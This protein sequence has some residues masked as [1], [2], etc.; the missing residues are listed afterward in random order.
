MSKRSNPGEVS[1]RAHKRRATA[2]QNE[3]SLLPFS[4]LPRSI[5]NIAL[6]LLTL[7]RR[8]LLPKP[9]SPSIPKIP[10]HLIA[11]LILPFVADRTTWDS[12]YCASKE[13]YLAGKKMTPPWP[14]NSFN[15]N[16]DPGHQVTY[17]TFSPSGSQ[18]A[19]VINGDQ[20]TAGHQYVGRVW[21]RW[22]KETLLAGHTRFIHCLEYS[23]DGEYLASGSQDGSIR[24]RH[25]D[26][27]QTMTSRERPTSTPEQADTILLGGSYGGF[28]TLSFS[29]TDSNLLVSGG[30]DNR[31]KIWN[32]RERICIQSFSPRRSA[33]VRSLILS[34]GADGVCIAAAAHGSKIR[35]WRAE[36]Y[37]RFTR[38]TISAAQEGQGRFVPRAVFSPS[39]SF[40]ATNMHSDHERTSTL[41][42]YD[43]GTMTKT[44]SVVMPGPMVTRFVISPDS[45]QLALCDRIGGIRL[46]QTD[47]FNIQ[48]DLVPRAGGSTPTGYALAFDPTSQILAF[49]CRR[50]RLE[51]RTL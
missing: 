18:V 24:V 33:S 9:P 39:G 36:G 26:S 41:S 29:R 15:L 35:L 5:W 3:E 42:L 38:R 47:D 46:V 40:L 25:T 6:G 23:S 21:D 14:D 7:P 45:K 51:L 27:F 4:S 34:G 1:S 43:L 48:R 28:R 13:L 44:Q 2:P 11:D 22:G 20:R 16:L 32:V 37:S 10:L 8:F 12:V 30:S 49:A 31:V 19:F 17:V 50:G